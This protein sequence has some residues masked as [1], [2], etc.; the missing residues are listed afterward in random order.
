MMGCGEDKNKKNEI[1][2]DFGTEIFTV[3]FLLFNMH[4]PASYTTDIKIFFSL[5]GKQCSWVWW[6]QLET[7]TFGLENEKFSA[8]FYA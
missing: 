5:F 4:A 1:K 6:A 7:G 2:Y 3:F 8:N